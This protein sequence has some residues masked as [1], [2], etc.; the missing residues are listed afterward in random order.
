MGSDDSGGALQRRL[1]ALGAATVGEAGGRTCRP[2]LRAAFPGARIAAP[3]FPVRCAPGDN[4]ALH[5]AVTAAP[6]GSALVAEV[7][8][9]PERGYWGEILTTAAEARGLV[10]LVIDGCV[11]D[12]AALAAHGFPVFAAG[13][14]LPGAAKVAGGAIGVPVRVAGAAVEPGDWVVADAD[15]V[16]VIPGP[17]LAEVLAA[18][19]ARQQR[20]EELI[21]RL[22]AGATTVE[23]LGLDPT[24]VQVGRP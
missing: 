17:A 1:L 7:S 15:G 4:L 21:R 14:A 6:P 24:A 22:R 10:G 3:A 12:V 23:L 16:A 18:A 20:E 19:E 2:G 8:A 5:V 11:R 9:D 13:L